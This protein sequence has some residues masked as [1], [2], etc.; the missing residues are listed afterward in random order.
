MEEVLG[1]WNCAASWKGHPGPG[2]HSRTEM[3]TGT[4]VQGSPLPGRD[5][6]LPWTMWS[7]SVHLRI[8]LVAKAALVSWLQEIWS[9]VAGRSQPLLKVYGQ[10]GSVVCHARDELLELRSVCGRQKTCCCLAYPGLE[11]WRAAHAWA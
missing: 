1:V 5:I 3:G 9:D 11:T 4:L 10:R 2:T 6:G 7:R 8:R